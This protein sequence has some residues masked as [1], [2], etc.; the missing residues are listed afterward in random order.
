LLQGRPQ[1]FA[2]YGRLYLS[3]NPAVVDLALDSSRLTLDLYLPALRSRPD[4]ELYDLGYMAA[5]NESPFFDRVAALFASQLGLA[6]A[7]RTHFFSVES[8]I[9][10]L[11]E[12]AALAFCDPGDVVLVPAGFPAACA[13]ALHLSGAVVQAVDPADLPARPPAAARLLFLSAADAAQP[14][15]DWALQNPAIQIFVDQTWAPIRGGAARAGGRV[16][17]F[18][19]LHGFLGTDGIPMCVVFSTE[20]AVLLAFRYALGAFRTSSYTE[21]LYRKILAPEVLAEVDRVLPGRLAEARGA[22]ARAFA[23]EGIAFSALEGSVYGELDVGLATPEAALAFARRLLEEK[24]VFVVPAAARVR[25][26]LARPLEELA[27]G[28]ARVVEGV[29]EFAV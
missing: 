21:W 25:V 13:G 28:I 7:D 1:S 3:R 12:R 23:A 4:L 5:K 20:P 29:K 2:E 24:G 18:F 6:S 8:D 10:L 17:A 14:L 27:R 9:A 11:Y 15:V 16:H 22:A 19:A 26:N